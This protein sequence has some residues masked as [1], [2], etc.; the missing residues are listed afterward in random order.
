MIPTC[1]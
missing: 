1:F